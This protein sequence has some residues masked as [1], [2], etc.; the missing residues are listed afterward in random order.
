MIKVDDRVKL[1]SGLLKR[2]GTV[3]IVDYELHYP[4]HVRW[5]YQPN[6]VIYTESEL[7][8]IDDGPIIDVD[9]LFEDIEI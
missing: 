2:H 9:K 1:K 7:I 6:T 5:D 3:K 4:I 8:V